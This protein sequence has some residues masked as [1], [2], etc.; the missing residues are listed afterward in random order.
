MTQ[1]TSLSEKM[2]GATV[3]IGEE[4]SV[5]Y[6]S[7]SNTS[8]ADEVSDG[9]PQK[10]NIDEEYYVKGRQAQ[11]QLS[12]EIAPSS[13]RIDSAPWTKSIDRAGQS[14]KDAAADADVLTVRMAEF[15]AQLA[16]F[17]FELAT[18]QGQVEDSQMSSSS[19]NMRQ[20]M[21]KKFADLRMAL[22]G[23]SET[24][25]D[26]ISDVKSD[27]SEVTVRMESSR[28]TRSIDRAGQSI[29]DIAA[30]AERLTLR[31]ARF[32][33]E[34]ATSQGQVEASLAGLSLLRQE[35][36]KELADVRML[37][38]TLSKETAH[39]VSHGGP[40]KSDVSAEYYINVRQAQ[41]QLSEEIASL[42]A[43]IDSA[44]WTFP[45]A[46]NQ[47]S[48][49]ITLSSARIDSAQ[50]DG[51]ADAMTFTIRMADFA[52][53]LTGFQIELATSQVQVEASQ[54]SLSNLRQDMR[55]ELADLRMALQ[56][57]VE[58]SLS[59][60]SILRQEVQNELAELRIASQGHKEAAEAFQPAVVETKTDAV[61][62]E[63]DSRLK[64]I[65]ELHEAFQRAVLKDIE[66]KTD[67]ID[68]E[69][70]RRLTD[71]VT[72]SD[73]RA[74]QVEATVSG[75]ST[76]RQEMKNELENL[77]M[78]SQD[79]RE[80]T[81]AFQS[82]VLRD[83]ET[84]ADAI[85]SE[86]NNR[87]KDIETKNEATASQVEATF[88][89]LSTLRQE[90]QNELAD[91]R[92]AS[93]EHKEVTEAFHSAVL[94]DIE[95]KSD[96]LVLEVNN[97]LKDM[98]TKSDSTAVQLKDRLDGLVFDGLVFD[99]LAAKLDGL[100]PRIEAAESGISTLFQTV[101]SVY[102]LWKNSKRATTV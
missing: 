5:F 101:E 80:A 1:T 14:M 39:E 45:A 68:L 6:R 16:G 40:Q 10:S 26:E 73:A 75:L 81:E 65:A 41:D 90:R 24:M 22:Q 99:G 37:S 93:Q 36:Q 102:K 17:H 64:E 34:L 82:T 74:L 25:A 13:A 77:R 91:L 2:N 23:R 29:K 28:W 55:K 42:T 9:E 47:L 84:K 57:Q 50:K 100:T 44:P 97:R 53:Q 79:R 67:T 31:M 56:G 27:I 46:Q 51:A 92:M 49:E 63:S 66:S 30:D 94:R 43:R 21:Q 69:L 3:K 89:S 8:T 32:S 87:L 52:A 83:I 35:M 95:T 70:N 62:L 76:S 59:D 58:A 33:A 38:Q 54:T 20:E 61:A 18:S 60:S 48:E 11:D 7:I 19:L 71:I 98:E 85:A 4:P 86:S 96:K 15:A 12:E 78:A 72:K 88:L